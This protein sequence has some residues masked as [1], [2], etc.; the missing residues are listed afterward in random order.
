LKKIKNMPSLD[1]RKK[2]GQK[3]KFYLICSI[4]LLINFNNCQSQGSL[5]E[6]RVDQSLISEWNHVA[7]QIAYEEDGF[8]T[9]IGIRTLTLLHLTCHDVLNAIEARY[10][11]YYFAKSYPDASPR[12]SISQAAY[13]ILLDAYPSRK[14]TLQLVYN[15]FVG[16]IPSGPA[17]K[18]GIRLGTV[19][20]QKFLELRK[21]D[22]HESQGGY[23]PMSKP[24]AYQYTPGFEDFV[25]KPDFK[26]ARPFALDSVTQFRSPEP[27]ELSSEI[28]TNSFIESKSY[29][30]KNSMLRSEDE[31]NY[32]HWWAE[33][34]EHSWNRMGRLVARDKHMD[35]WEAARMFALI[36][37]DIYDIYLASLESKYF[38]DTWRPVTAIRE[39][40]GDGNPQTIQDS[41][42][43]PE[44]QTPPWPEY[45]S[46]HAAVGAGGAEILKH[47]LGTAEVSVSMKSITGLS[48]AQVRAF[49][50]LD[51]AAEEC[52]NSRIMNGFH[53]RFATDE[54]KNQGKEVA[55]YILHNYLK[56]IE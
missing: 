56:P 49:D 15:K 37:M 53:F 24:G 29:G 30:G 47:I 12:A 48:S 1:L 19:V 3:I 5:P 43:E 32:A 54:G 40:A 50:N 41:S 14:D 10:E 34:G 38:Y 28:Y 20:A 52:A 4:S 39:A 36:N 42:W 7:Y 55:R 6:D 23:R 25:F 33:F 11:P 26:K 13:E 44:M 9:L 17:K 18:M 31:T 51:T 16:N 2:Q 8:T 45:P 27:P 35:V 22:G 21:G 46:A